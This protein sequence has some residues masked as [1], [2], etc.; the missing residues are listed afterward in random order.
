MTSISQMA[1]AYE[2]PKMGNI[3]DL[4]RVSTQVKIENK[5]FKEGTPEQWDCNVITVEGK[6]YRVPNS[7]LAGLKT[8]LEIK[9]KTAAFKVV[10]Q[11]EGLNT[12][13]TVVDLE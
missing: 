3:A 7:V 6:E 9:P 1:T 8:L 12:N 13:Y 11:G 10:R 2:V 5:V 4:D